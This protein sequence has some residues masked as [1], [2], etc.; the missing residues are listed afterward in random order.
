MVR[1][2]EEVSA[3][4]KLDILKESYVSYREVA[5]LYPITENA[6]KKIVRDIYRGLKEKNVPVFNTRPK[7]IP[8]DTLLEKHPINI[9]ALERNKKNAPTHQEQSI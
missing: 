5:K 2:I 1:V 3:Q 7:I 8:L 4:E 6:A 9:K